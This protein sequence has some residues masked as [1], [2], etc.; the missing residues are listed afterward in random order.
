MLYVDDDKTPVEVKPALTKLLRTF[1]DLKRWI[2]NIDQELSKIAKSV[3]DTEQAASPVHTTYT[4]STCENDEADEIG[5]AAFS[6]FTHISVTYED[7]KLDELRKWA[8]TKE[9][10]KQVREMIES[11]KEWILLGRH[12][13]NML[14]AFANARIHSY[15]NTLTNYP[16][17]ATSSGVYR[18]GRE[19]VANRV[20]RLRRTGDQ[21]ACYNPTK[22]EDCHRLHVGTSQLH[23][24]SKYCARYKT[25]QC[26]TDP[27]LSSETATTVKETNT[28]VTK[29]T[30]LIKIC[31]FRAP[32]LERMCKEC[33]KNHKDLRFDVCSKCRLNGVP[34]DKN[35]Q[36]VPYRPQLKTKVTYSIRFDRQNRFHS[37]RPDICV[38]RNSPWVTTHNRN[39]TLVNGGNTDLQLTFHIGRIISYLYSYLAKKEVTKA[40]VQ[41]H[42]NA[43]LRALSDVLESSYVVTLQ[44][45]VSA[46]IAGRT[47]S[48][49]AA[50][51]QILGLPICDTNI[52]RDCIFINSRSRK[53][54]I[55]AKTSEDGP[56]L[57]VKRDYLDAYAQR[58]TMVGEDGDDG[59]Y[60]H[61]QEYCLEQFVE[62]CYHQSRKG[63]LAIGTRVKRF[64]TYS[65]YDPVLKFAD[66]TY[67]FVH[68]VQFPELFDKRLKNGEPKDNKMYWRWCQL[69]LTIHKPWIKNPLKL[70]GKYK[71]IE[72]VP[73]TVFISKWLEFVGTT[74]RGREVQ[75][76]FDRHRAERTSCK[77]QLFDLD[78]YMEQGWEANPDYQC[79]NNVGDMTS[80]AT[81]KAEE[82]LQ[83]G[84]KW[85]VELKARDKVR[86]TY[87][88]AEIS[89]ATSWI[90]KQK[91]EQET[92]TTRDFGHIDCRDMDDEQKIMWVILQLACRDELTINGEKRQVLMQMR[93]KPGSGKSFVLKCA[94]TD[95]QFQKHARL[96]ATTG[97]AGCLIGGTTI[98]SL[99]LL[100]FKHARRGQLDGDDKHNVETRLR[101][102][103][104][105]IIDEK[106]MFS[107]E[108]LGWLDM[109]LR[110]VQPDKEKKLKPFGGYHIFFFGDFRQIQPVGGRVMYD[111]TKIDEDTK[112]INMV[113]K[114]QELYDEIKD[115]L[116]LKNNH[117]VK[118]DTDD[119]T[120]RFIEEMTKIG[121][122]T[123]SAKDWEFWQQFMDH[124]DPAKTE[125]FARDP[126]TTFLFPTN[127]QAATTNSDHV[128]TTSRDT[129][130]YQWPA[131]NTGR[132]GS[133]K[134]DKVNMLRPYLGVR[135][136]SNQ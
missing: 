55:G 17:K 129:T 51:W 97:S 124:V 65:Q 13:E 9:G 121:D 126:K 43:S 21:T 83:A 88:D 57:L 114:G 73:K 36:N 68:M 34:F 76:R 58:D 23:V 63:K 15:D 113:E 94:Q 70:W 119:L 135:E 79:G 78:K 89:A 25:K 32:W 44:R 80:S 90:E 96:A 81:S 40:D 60:E 5:N 132:A 99:V 50:W 107:Q 27:P 39:A 123:C 110:A 82:I 101:D 136:G 47:F 3:S 61:V 11:Y 116:E 115:V 12:A 2:V 64:K 84:R 87:T 29:K 59:F 133:A 10:D 105:I 28:E 45:A 20:T 4:D 49:Q 6:S 69:Q 118:E 77:D 19:D 111:K 52:K 31:K 128:S 56:R 125:A 108:Q 42:L 74:E 103:R 67:P 100:S 127:D 92:L 106:S 48:T 102:V 41:R 62:E 26:K 38:R 122:G 22:Y 86:G 72:E 30:Q 66:K 18:Q 37:A 1:Q 75:N 24:C 53:L 95:D 98:H 93:G 85:D 131:T 91:K 109:R 8:T 16:E 120:R 134:L 112:W 33:H 46:A 7:P 54:N 71:S 117:R 104:V 14:I 35:A 130:L